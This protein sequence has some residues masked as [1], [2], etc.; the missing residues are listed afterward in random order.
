MKLEYNK[1]RRTLIVHTDAEI[2]HHSAAQ[3][4]KKI[5][6]EFMRTRAEHIVFDFSDL[7][8]MDSSGIGLIIGRYRLIRPLCGKVVLAGVSEQMDRIISLSGVYKLTEWAKN[9]EDA[10]ALI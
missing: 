8:F 4:R 7:K 5:D 9:T 2:D 10:L 1:Q 6:E 3:M